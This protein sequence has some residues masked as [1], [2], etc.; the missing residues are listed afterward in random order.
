MRDQ[1]ESNPPFVV[2]LEVSARQLEAKPTFFLHKE[3]PNRLSEHTSLKLK[4]GTGGLEPFTRRT[5]GLAL[6]Y[7]PGMGF[8]RVF[9][10]LKR[11]SLLC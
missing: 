6:F 7:I 11:E 3:C 5:N 1:L 9:I 4:S 10:V 8:K 2:P